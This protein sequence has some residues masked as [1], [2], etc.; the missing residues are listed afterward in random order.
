[1]FKVSFNIFVFFFL[2]RMGAMEGLISLCTLCKS[3][4]KIQMFNSIASIF[5]T[6]EERV[7]VGSH[8]NFVVNLRNIQS[9]E[10]LFT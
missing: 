9:Y 1:M 8:T 3:C 6:N 2:F 4:Y 10:N 7:M 5:G